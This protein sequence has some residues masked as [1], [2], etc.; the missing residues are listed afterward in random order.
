M[1]T[2]AEQLWARILAHLRQQGRL[3]LRSEQLTPSEIAALCNDGVSDE[4][5]HRFVHDYYYPHHFGDTA[6]A[7]SDA[8]AN[9]LVTALESG[10]AA[11]VHSDAASPA[12]PMRRHTCQICERRAVPGQPS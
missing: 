9:E 4:R 5:V 2:P 3:P 1:T 7:L 8:K 10:V 6:G 12:A 11:D